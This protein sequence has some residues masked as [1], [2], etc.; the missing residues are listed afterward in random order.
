MAL[1]LRLLGSSVRRFQTGR[2]AV[3]WR[4][5]CP[6]PLA[7]PVM[8]KRHR[9]PRPCPCGGGPPPATNPNCAAVLSACPGG[10]CVE[11]GASAGRRDKT[12]HA[13]SQR[14]NGGGPKAWV[15]HGRRGRVTEQARPTVA[16][17]DDRACATPCTR[18]TY[19]LRIERW[20]HGGLALMLVLLRRIELTRSGSF[21]AL[22]MMRRHGRVA[23]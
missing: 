18:A 3:S 23:Q 12:T 13:T 10:S 21:L 14:N 6:L 1:A 7:P 4:C 19:G 11:C 20:A 5:C 8:H 17:E 22:H 15:N 16:K 2:A 9:W